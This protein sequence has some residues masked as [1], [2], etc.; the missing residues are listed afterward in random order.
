[1]TDYKKTVFAIWMI[2]ATIQAEAATLKGIILSNELSGPP[3]PNVE[4]TAAVGANPIVSDSAGR[5]SL[6]FPQKSPG[7]WVRIVVNRPGHVVVNDIQLELA[8]PSDTNSRPVS[9]LLCKEGDREEMA[10]RFYRL[11][12]LEVIEETYKRR[13]KELE[14]RHQADAAAIAK[15]RVERDQAIAAA[16]RSA[17]EFAREKPVQTTEFYRQAMRL[18]LDG[19]IDE[20]LRVL[21]EVT[22]QRSLEIARRKKEEGEKEIEQVVQAFLLKGRLLTAQFCFDEATMAYRA[23]V[24]AAPANFEANF[25]FAFFYQSLRRYP[26]AQ[27]YYQICLELTRRNGNK[28]Q[29]ALTLNNLGNLHRAQNHLTEALGAHEEALSTRRELATHN[30]D[31][32]LSDLAFTL[33]NLGNVYRDLNRLTEAR[34]AYEEA[35]IIRRKLAANKLE[36]DLSRVADTLCS[37]GNLNRDQNRIKDASHAFEEALTICRDLCIRNP[38]TYLPQLS[39][40]LN[41]L[42]VLYFNQNRME[43]ASLVYEEALKIRRKLAIQNP[44]TYLPDVATTL[45][46]LGILHSAQNRLEQARTDYEEALNIDREL[47]VR[48]SYAYLPDVATTLNNLG[49]LHFQ[50][51]RMT[52]ALKAHEEALLIRRELTTRSPEGF[53]PDLAFTLN[54]LG[55]VYR[56]GFATGIQIAI[57]RKLSCRGWIGLGVLCTRSVLNTLGVMSAS[58]RRMTASNRFNFSTFHRLPA[59]C[60]QGFL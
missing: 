45:N 27:K 1:M 3:M 53:L 58:L 5:F 10:R 11:K 22:L 39:M 57:C 23:A 21:N 56:K 19:K 50:H 20:A 48:D 37:L 4:V 51:N 60:S 42:G 14:D 2:I 24:K 54:N 17:D 18:F 33:N 32:Y 12:T 28:E 47:A 38:K 31:A 36:T 59:T 49:I 8:L 29:I 30:S 34:K 46:N 44:D 40:I 25:H 35:L 43:H 26:E 6:D 15:L 52:D 16:E 55:N 13:L 9:I 41:S 7:D